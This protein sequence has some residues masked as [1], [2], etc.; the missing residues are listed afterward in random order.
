[1]RLTRL[2]LPEDVDNFHFTIAVE[3]ESYV[4]IKEED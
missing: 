2:Q 4:A 1:M 3:D